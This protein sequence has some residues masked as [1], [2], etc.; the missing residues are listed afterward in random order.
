MNIGTFKPENYSQEQID[1]L[2]HLLGMLD[3]A[4]NKRKQYNQIGS[5]KALQTFMDDPS[6]YE[7]NDMCQVWGAIP[8]DRFNATIDLIFG[9]DLSEKHANIKNEFMHLEKSKKQRALSYASDKFRTY[10]SETRFQQDWR[11]VDSLFEQI[12]AEFP[13]ILNETDEIIAAMEMGRVLLSQK[14]ELKELWAYALNS[15][16]LDMARNIIKTAYPNDN[17]DNIH[18]QEVDIEKAAAAVVGGLEADTIILGQMFFSDKTFDF[19]L[20][21]MNHEF[22]HRRQRRLVAQLDNGELEKATAKYY[23]ARLFRANFSDLGGGYLSPMSA[24]NKIVRIAGLRDYMEQPVEQH[25]NNMAVLSHKIAGT[26]GGT[27]WKINEGITKIFSDV[28]RPAAFVYHTVRTPFEKMHA[29]DATVNTP[30]KVE[31][32]VTKRKITL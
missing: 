26:T 6:L 13:E 2:E 4:T 27:L 11:A 24:P 12:L 8:H 19:P 16:K 25:A 30:E 17:V 32:P 18:M 23:Q 22:N 3:V 10:L 29:N 15:E 5:F 14:N 31:R 28:C 9:K 21:L 1:R 20:Y 7:E